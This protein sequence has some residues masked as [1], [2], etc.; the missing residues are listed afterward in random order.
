MFYQ[1]T[2]A[3][4]ALRDKIREFAETEVKPVAFL[5]DQEKMCIRDRISGEI[6]RESDTAS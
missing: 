4:E 3:H 2:E 5:L 6:W 1:T